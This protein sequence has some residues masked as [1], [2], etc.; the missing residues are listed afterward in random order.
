MA[1][2]HAPKEKCVM[3]RE[4]EGLPFVWASGDGEH[5]GHT[6]VVRMRGK[7]VNL[8][9]DCQDYPLHSDSNKNLKFNSSPS[10]DGGRRRRYV[11]PMSLAEVTMLSLREKLQIM[12]AIWIDLRQHVETLDIPAS[13]LHILEERSARVAEGKSA[14]LDWD[15]VKHTIGKT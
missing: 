15:K 13:H 11:P 10:V 6:F 8:L 2:L 12:E 4:G 14:L 1:I 9:G 3:L 7:S 5:D